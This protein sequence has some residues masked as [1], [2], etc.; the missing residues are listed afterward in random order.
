M[1]LKNYKK[2]LNKKGETLIEV[3]IALFVVTLGATT[4]TSLIVTALRSNQFNKDSLIALNLAQEGLEFMRNL[5]DSNWL[6]FSANTQGCWNMKPGVE[7][8]K[9]SDMLEENNDQNGYTL[10]WDADQIDG[11]FLEKLDTKL[12]LKDGIDEDEKKYRLNQYVIDEDTGNF[13]TG[14]SFIGS[15]GNPLT[16][17][18]VTKFYRMIEIDYKTISASA[19]WNISPAASAQVAD[20]MVVTSTIYWMEGGAQ[21]EVKLSSALTRYK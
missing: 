10:G 5:R 15:D 16:A 18:A 6:R 4:A 3:L 12:N 2:K 1:F 11:F 13:F 8:C 21:H 9:D 14:S 20:M 7:T 19:P 17:D